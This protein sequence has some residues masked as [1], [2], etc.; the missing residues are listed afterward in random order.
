MIA[1]GFD[2]VQGNTAIVP[3]MMYDEPLA[4][5]MA[6]MRPLKACM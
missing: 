6:D 3:V 4:M 5:K 1:A 2:I